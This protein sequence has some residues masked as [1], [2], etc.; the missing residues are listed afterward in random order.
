MGLD[1]HFI[2]HPGIH[3]LIET[4]LEVK[5]AILE[6]YNESV[7]YNIDADTYCDLTP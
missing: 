7:V 6:K 5:Q 4:T 2:A 1:A 3:G